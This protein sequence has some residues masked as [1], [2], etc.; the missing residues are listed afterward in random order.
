[1]LLRVQARA[2]SI[3]IRRLR[4]LFLQ[5]RWSWKSLPKAHFFHVRFEE[6]LVRPL[7]I[8]SGYLPFS[9]GN[10]ALD[11]L[12]V[13]VSFDSMSDFESFRSVLGFDF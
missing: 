1:M 7:A 2:R 6:K 13:E 11:D 8:G 12:F 10:M 3:V 5:G 4:P 9:A